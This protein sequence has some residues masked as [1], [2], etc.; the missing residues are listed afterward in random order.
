MGRWIA[1]Y[2][3]WHYWPDHVISSNPLI[4]EFE[5]FH[6]TDVPC[7]HQVPGIPGKWFMSFIAFNGQGY[8]SF[9]AESNDLIHWENMRLVMGF[10]NAGEFD[11]GGRV[12]GAFLYDSYD[13]R[14]PRILKKKTSRFWTLYGCYAK[15]GGYEIDPG[16]EGIASS[17]DGLTWKRAM[18]SPILSVYDPDAGSWEKDCIYQPWLLEHEGLF[19]DFYNAKRMPE[20][21][22]QIGIATSI[23]LLN[24]KRFKENPVIRVRPGA[25]DGCFLGDGT[26]FRDGDHWVMF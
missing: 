3:G 14:A 13:I 17:D 26:V 1:P 22:E 8:N 18:E 16:Y 19:Y 11:F 10:G 21:V 6:N 9:L 20:W 23:D 2:K 15:Q 5:S 25:C 12:I 4:P 24:W 7:V